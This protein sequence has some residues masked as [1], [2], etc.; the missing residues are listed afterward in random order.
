MKFSQRLGYYSFGFIVGMI[1]LFF[2]LGGKKTSCDYSPNARVLKNIRIKE[3]KFSDQA[4]LA[5]SDKALD[6]SHISKILKSGNVDFS[7]SNTNKITCKEY[8]I[9]GNANEKRIGL[10]VQNC[11]S[12]AIIHTLIILK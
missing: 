8:F 6:T 5:M 9:E 2:F 11:D 12:I 1:L 7:K 10:T 4:L 3:R